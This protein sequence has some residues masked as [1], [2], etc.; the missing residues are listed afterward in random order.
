[1]A[2]AEVAVF[3][4]NCILLLNALFDLPER[5]TGFRNVVV[6]LAGSLSVLHVEVFWEKDRPSGGGACTVL[7]WALSLTLFCELAKRPGRGGSRARWPHPG[8]DKSGPYGP[9][10][11]LR[12]AFFPQP[13]TIRT[14]PKTRILAKIN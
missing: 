13:F 2:P 14:Y 7:G 5:S 6:L 11:S 3:N 10:P 4:A 12:S 1:M 9:S 8:R